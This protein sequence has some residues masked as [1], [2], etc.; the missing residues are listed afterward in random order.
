MSEIDHRPNGNGTKQSYQTYSVTLSP[1][2][3]LLNEQRTAGRCCKQVHRL[4][5]ERAKVLMTETMSKRWWRQATRVRTGVTA[6]LRI[7][8]SGWNAL[9]AG[10]GGGWKG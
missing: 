9:L 8:V 4:A 10:A 5:S 6:A 3:Q 1:G 2:R 7:K